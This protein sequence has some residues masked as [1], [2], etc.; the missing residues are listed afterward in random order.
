MKIRIYDGSKR[1]HTQ[2]CCP[3]AELDTATKQ[4]T[5]HD[6]A[7]P[8]NGSFVMTADEWNTLLQHATPVA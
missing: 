3:V 4:V 5:V 8:E 6:P 2:Q 1:C 7:K